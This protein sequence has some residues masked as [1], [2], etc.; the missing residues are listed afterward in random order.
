MTQMINRDIFKGNAYEPEFAVT[1]KKADTGALVPATGIVG[2]TIRIAAVKNGPAIDPSLQAVAV[3]RPA[4]AGYFVV[5]PAFSIAVI[6]AHLFPAYD[7]KK[8]FV[9]LDDGASVIVNDP[10]TCYSERLAG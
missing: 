9:I 5:T 7:G 4:K 10:V 8:V 6:N 3:E 1:K 2:A